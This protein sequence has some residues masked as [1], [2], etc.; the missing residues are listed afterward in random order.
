VISPD[1]GFGTYDGA[2]V[3]VGELGPGATAICLEMFENPRYEAA[4]P[5]LRHNYITF[6][7]VRYLAGSAL[8]EIAGDEIVPRLRQLYDEAQIGPGDP[9]R[10]AD[11][12]ASV[13]TILSL[14]GNSS[15]FEQEL[16]LRKMIADQSRRSLVSGSIFADVAEMYLKSNRNRSCVRWYRRAAEYDRYLNRPVYL[17]NIACAFSRMGELER[18][19]AALE[20][21]VVAGYAELSWLERDGDLD[22]LRGDPRFT[23]IVEF[24]VSGGETGLPGLSRSRRGGFWDLL[25]PGR[26]DED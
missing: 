2:F 19:L 16:Q 18:G 26:D 12:E 3:H 22:F 15:R 4:T 5:A 11:F 14:H 20:E 25:L 7:K 9:E 24:I 21:A 8:Y 6:G 1:G 17:Y 23:Q 10:L 13:A